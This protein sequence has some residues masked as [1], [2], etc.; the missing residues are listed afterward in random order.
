MDNNNPDHPEEKS[1]LQLA[2]ER[3]SSSIK[4]FFIKDGAPKKRGVSLILTLL[5]SFA[6]KKKVYDK[7]IPSSEM[8]KLIQNSD[9]RKV[10]LMVTIIV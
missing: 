2:V 5:L 3:V 4:S 8:M 1:K 9:I 7:L 6:F 10:I